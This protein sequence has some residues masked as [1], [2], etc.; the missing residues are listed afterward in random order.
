MC[1]IMPLFIFGIVCA[2]VEF[3]LHFIDPCENVNLIHATSWHNFTNNY[4]LFTKKG[5][6][7]DSP[8]FLY[9]NIRSH[10]V[11]NKYSSVVLVDVSGELLS[12]R[13]ASRC[14][15]EWVRNHA[16]T[17]LEANLRLEGVRIDRT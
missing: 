11:L 13:N 10:E 1:S 17:C 7:E 5:E 16:I 9:V 15:N 14:L 12:V 6:S 4:I 2:I 8:V 3:V